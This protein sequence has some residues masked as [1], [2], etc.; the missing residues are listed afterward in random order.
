MDLSGLNLRRRVF[1]SQPGQR[2]SFANTSWREA[3]LC[4][5][6]FFEVDLTGC[7]FSGIDGLQSIWV[8]CRLEGASFGGADL[9]RSSWRD[10]RLDVDALKT[11]VL[12]DAE[13]VASHVGADEMR[14]GSPDHHAFDWTPSRYTNSPST[15]MAFGKIGGRDV[16][17]CA[18]GHR[19]G[20]RVWEA[21]TGAPILKADGLRRPIHRLALGQ[22]A[23]RDVVI[24]SDGTETVHVWDIRAACR[25]PDLRSGVEVFA[26]SLGQIDGRDVMAAADRTGNI[27]IYDLLDRTVLLEIDH[28]EAPMSLAFGRQWNRDV[29]AAGDQTGVPHIWD[30]RTG[31][32]LSAFVVPSSWTTAIA[33][34]RQGDRDIV[35]T[36]DDEGAMRVWDASSAHLL[37][38]CDAGQVLAATASRIG[39]REVVISAEGNGGV[40]IWAGLIED[41]TP[42]AV[43][44]PQT[45]GCIR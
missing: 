8:D 30:A 39:N 25:L 6:E 38:T 19:L 5:T 12:T 41:S 16:V 21:L 3:I 20:V 2:V 43:L 37:S 24:A 7:D 13:T 23:E 32:K 18:E 26:V 40:Q 10:C 27:R 29:V 34:G 44:E 4:Q 14:L 33:L 15:I 9:S 11:A 42:L 22:I 36:A 31:L 35:I 28:T 1:R 45:A 17:A